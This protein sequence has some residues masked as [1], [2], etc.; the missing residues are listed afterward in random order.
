MKNT[1]IPKIQKSTILTKCT[2]FTKF[3]KP[4]KP[5]KCTKQKKCTKPTKSTKPTIHTKYTIFTE[6]TKSTKHIWQL[7]LYTWHHPANSSLRKESPAELMVL[8]FVWNKTVY[9]TERSK[10]EN[11][12]YSSSAPCFFHGTRLPLGQRRAK[13][14]IYIPFH[15]LC[16]SSLSQRQFRPI[17]KKRA[18]QLC[19]PFSVL[20]L[21]VPEAV[22][23]HTKVRRIS[24][25]RS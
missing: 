11:G 3:T 10:T 7:A 25:T 19:S 20:L 15:Y 23:S 9:G 1:Q 8:T 6:P 21:A 18:D 13:Q 4:S 24:L 2:K 16:C 14:R 5:L 22:L 12:L 17:Q